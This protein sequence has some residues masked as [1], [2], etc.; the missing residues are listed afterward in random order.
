[1]FD[2]TAAPWASGP[3]DVRLNPR[4]EVRRR[5][6][7]EEWNWNR[8]RCGDLGKINGWLRPRESRDSNS[9][10]R[11]GEGERGGTVHDG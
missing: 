3:V 4:R 7:K 11:E 1:M 10:E 6:T 9:A 5:D 8:G 2:G